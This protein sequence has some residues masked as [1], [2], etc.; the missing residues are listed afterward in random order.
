MGYVIAA[1]VLVLGTL[2]AYGARLH[3]RRR[4]FKQRAARLKVDGRTS[5]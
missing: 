3:A 2:I 1:Y 4:A 5:R